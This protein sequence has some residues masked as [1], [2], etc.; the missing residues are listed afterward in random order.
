MIFKVFSVTVVHGVP[1]STTINVL[2]P[3]GFSR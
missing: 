2:T 1:G 3:N